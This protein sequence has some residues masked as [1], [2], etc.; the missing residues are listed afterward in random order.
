M[1]NPVLNFNFQSKTSQSV[2]VI[3]KGVE[4]QEGFKK[5]EPANE[6]M[7]TLNQF[8]QQLPTDQA[9]ILNHI[10]SFQF[11]SA[12][13]LKTITYQP[14]LATKSTASR[15]QNASARPTPKRHL[16]IGPTFAFGGERI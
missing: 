6:G 9:N 3:N 4:K 16:L 5:V 14:L 13:Q 10:V 1:H 15:G 11:N 2:E 12:L 7:E 8:Q